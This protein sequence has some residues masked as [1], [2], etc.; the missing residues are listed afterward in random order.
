MPRGGA[1]ANAGRKKNTP[2]RATIARQERVANSG[3]TPLEVM[4]ED[5]RFHYDLY[6]EALAKREMAEASKE[7][8]LARLAAKDAAPYSHS[9]LATI[10]H[11]GK[12]GGPIEFTDARDKL[13]HLI[14]R[15][16]DAAD[17]GEDSVTAH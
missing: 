11:M 8:A 12:C 16:A 14:A 13:S 1:R 7:M 15:A 4:L 3:V 10:E 5:M 6:Q 17:E 9:R 2:S